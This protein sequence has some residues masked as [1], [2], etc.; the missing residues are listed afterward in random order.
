MKILL[1]TEARNISNREIAEN[2][3]YLIGLFDRVCGFTGNLRAKLTSNN[4]T[5]AACKTRMN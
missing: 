3:A 1:Q 4:K 2:Q 5:I